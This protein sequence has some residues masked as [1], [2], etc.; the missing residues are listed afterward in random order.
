IMLNLANPDIAFKACMMPND[1]VGLARMEFIINEY[2]KIHPMAL[3]HPERIA[4]SGERQTI[5]KL[6]AGH[7]SLPDYFIQR[8]SEGIGTIAAAFYQKPVIVRLSDFKTNEYAAL[9][10]GRAFE[11]QEENPML[12]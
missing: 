12:G 8:L 2:I 11:P 4:D 3:V 9:L 10:G 7:D 5:E 1:G 6:C